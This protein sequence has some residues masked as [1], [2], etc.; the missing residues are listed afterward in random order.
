MKNSKK[1]IVTA[2]VISVGM[3]AAAASATL[4]ATKAREM[5]RS[6]ERERQAAQSQLEL[7][8][9]E[10]Y[11]LLREKD[12]EI[13]ALTAKEAAAAQRWPT[14]KAA[15]WM[16]AD[17]RIGSSDAGRSP[18]NRCRFHTPNTLRRS[19]RRRSSCRTRICTY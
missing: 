12:A 6:A 13:H 11:A 15:V 16:A 19:R 3:M 8:S 7:R 18:R 14:G 2:G 17:G 9:A 4:D 5:A 10:A 1:L